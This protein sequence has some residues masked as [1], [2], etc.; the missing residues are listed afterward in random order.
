MAEVLVEHQREVTMT[1]P[2]GSSIAVNRYL[3]EHLEQWFNGAWE[4]F[5]GTCNKAVA[6][7]PDR[8]E[9][10]LVVQQHQMR[11]LGEELAK[12]REILRGLLDGRP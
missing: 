5:C 7:A 9:A 11:H 12:V 10:V 1:W 2:D 3:L 6:E 8:I 4:V